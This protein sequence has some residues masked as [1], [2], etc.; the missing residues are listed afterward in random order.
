M[1][2]KFGTRPFHTAFAPL[3]LAVLLL[4]A[5]LSQASARTALPAQST[6]NRERLLNG[7][8]FFVVPQPSTPEVSLL[9]RIHSGASFDLA[10]KE[11]T[12]ALL[13]RSLFPDEST[14]IYVEEELGG[15]M[16]VITDYDAIN[17]RLSGRAG[18]LETLVELLRNAIVP[19]T[20]VDVATLNILRT[21]YLTELKENQQATNSSSSSTTGL[22][23]DRAVAQRLF[24]AYPLGRLATGTPE[25]LARV[26]RSDLM[27]ARSRFLA[28][29][30]A[31]LVI[32]GSVAPTRARLILRQYLGSWRKSD[33]L[34]Q[35]TFRQPPPPKSNLSLLPA[36][37]DEPAELRVA[38]RAPAR[39]DRDY[40]AAAI[41][42]A[43]LRER[44]R[45]PAGTNAG[46][47][48]VSYDAYKLAG[49][50]SV[51]ATTAFA[52]ASSR[53][54]VIRGTL[55]ALASTAPPS[56]AEIERARSALLG[57]S[58]TN[59]DAAE[60]IAASYLD[61]DT[62][63]ASAGDTAAKLRAVTLANVQ[64]LASKLLVPTNMAIVVAGD[65]DKLE[66]E[67]VKSATTIEVLGTSVTA[68]ATPA[69]PPV[70]SNQV[71]STPLI[72]APATPA[73]KRP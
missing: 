67:L 49:I 65:K 19:N 12:M 17:I 45:Q 40:A 71:P 23:A 54:S 16:S 11:G 59:A 5:P 61:A 37:S 53:L 55:S 70:R 3:A 57:V 8:S 20:T 27:L 51:K 25:S 24:G 30:N 50:L 69:R 31:T 58:S 28:P 18:S 9:L 13:A 35:A 26:Q 48:D 60:S 21:R 22:L 62:Y 15:R 36:S 1:H 64:R 68:E 4:T 14:R 2:H 47:F 39:T 10:G 34:A 56:S 33:S 6:A 29:D 44:L 66:T 46:G 32:V 38:L 72:P 63:G 73:V 42:S 7:L 41:L 43:L 52:D